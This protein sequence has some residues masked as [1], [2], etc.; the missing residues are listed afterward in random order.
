MWRSN[1]KQFHCSV[2]LDDDNDI[3]FGPSP[4]TV[5]WNDVVIF[6][7]PSSHDDQVSI[8]SKWD[9]YDD[10]EEKEDDN[11][12]IPRQEQLMTTGPIAI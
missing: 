1:I 7:R 8:A 6:V 3:F 5:Q 12:D 2:H 10:K 11:D 4:T 9:N